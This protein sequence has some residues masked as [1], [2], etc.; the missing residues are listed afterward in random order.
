MGWRGVVRRHH[1]SPIVAFRR[2]G[3]DPEALR[4]PGTAT[5]PLCS[6]D[7]GMIRI[8]HK[9]GILAN[10]QIFDLEKPMQ[11]AGAEAPVSDIKI[12]SQRQVGGMGWEEQWG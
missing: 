2:A 1:H 10:K 9:S 5:L 6:R 4:A 8:R 7:D 11:A 12:L 3:Q